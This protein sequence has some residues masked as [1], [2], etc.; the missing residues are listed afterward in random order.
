MESLKNKKR[1]ARNKKCEQ[2]KAFNE[3][4]NSLDTAELRKESVN[5][6]ICP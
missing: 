2:T 3:F 5:L 6:I 4:T 1:N